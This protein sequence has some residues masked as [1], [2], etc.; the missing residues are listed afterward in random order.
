M[1]SFNGKLLEIPQISIDH[2]DNNDQQF[3]FLSHLHSD[4]LK[5]IEKLVTNSPFFA[6]PISSFIIKKKYPHL[7]VEELE[8]GYSRNLEIINDDGS[9]LSF[10]VTSISAG[11]CMGACMF[12]FQIEG[13]DILY[14]GDIRISLDNAKN[15]KLLK[16][17]RD[18]GNLVLYLDS[19]FMKSSYAKFP[20]QRESIAAI[21][22]VIKNH[23]DASSSHKGEK[24]FLK[25]Q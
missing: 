20:S 24:Y 12:L 11:H 17:V 14:T 19:T 15:I 1:S 21:I 25:F 10:V 7:Q 6:S 9:S 8:V 13:T 23:L 5:G 22:T 16:E 18:Y 2:F 4:H 3:Y